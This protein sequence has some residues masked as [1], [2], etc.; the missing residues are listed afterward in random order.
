MHTPY[1]D[2]VRR[3]PLLLAVCAL[4][5][6]AGPRQRAA[7][8]AVAA[9]AGP[10][11]KVGCTRS[12]RLGYFRELRTKEFLC[13][14]QRGSTECDR[15]V[16]RVVQRRFVVTLAQRNADCILPPS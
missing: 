8:K 5:A 10:G 16:A 6:C 13:L 4:A 15:Y 7:E 14:V 9:V 3:L 11:V 1:D 12:A 2:V